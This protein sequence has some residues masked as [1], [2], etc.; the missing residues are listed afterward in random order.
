MIVEPG[1]R[2]VR[3]AERVLATTDTKAIT[4]PN[5]LGHSQ[6]HQASPAITPQA[7]GQRRNQSS[8]GNPRR[9][10]TTSPATPRQAKSDRG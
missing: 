8:K 6:S 2:A 3:K 10:P 4:S 5:A 1:S 9:W 7:C